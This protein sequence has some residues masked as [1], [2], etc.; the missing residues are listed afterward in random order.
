MNVDFELIASPNPVFQELNLRVASGDG[1]PDVW[2]EVNLEEAKKLADDG[3]AIPDLM[4]YIEQYCPNYLN[5]LEVAGGKERNLRAV[6]ADGKVVAFARPTFT[7]E[8]GDAIFARKDW[9]EKLGLSMPKTTDDLFQLAKAL[10]EKGADLGCKY[11]IT[12]GPV[13]KDAQP[14]AGFQALSQ[15]F[16][17]PFTAFL[18][19]DKLAWGPALP[20]RKDFL[21]Y[22]K[23]FVDEKLLPEDWYLWI[24]PEGFDKMNPGD[25]GVFVGGAWGAFSGG[26]AK[27]KDFANLEFIKWVDGPDGHRWGFK[28]ESTSI[29]SEQ[30]STELLKDEAK[31]KRILHIQ[32]QFANP[33]S[34]LAKAA[35]HRPYQMDPAFENGDCLVRE[36]KE[37]GAFVQVLGWAQAD[38]QAVDDATKQRCPWL[39][40]EK[41]RQSL[42]EW[43][44]LAVS[45]WTKQGYSWAGPGHL[46][47]S[48]FGE[49]Y[50]MK[51]YWYAWWAQLADQQFYDTVNLR[52][53]PAAQTDLNKY[54]YA[55]ELK[56]VLNQRPLDEWDAYVA[57]LMGKYKAKELLETTLK[58]LQDA[59]IGVTGLDER[60]P[61]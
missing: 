31:L 17:A 20:A 23:Q 55:N 35:S 4:P 34:S 48:V 26:A 53:D 1:A 10:K 38:L 25:W 49:K 21:A 54:I 60:M 37:D 16:G 30:L 58:A 13:F 52:G 19:K 32:D 11:G 7:G 14:L 24:Y 47:D 51:D 18:E 15:L 22:V 50:H 44:P 6:T 27:W 28:G 33:Y 46:E 5:L 45:V 9:V 12:P 29:V 40:D 56:F 43:R 8:P 42:G 3:V 41:A 2:W 36:F 61:G 57:D 39:A 59:G